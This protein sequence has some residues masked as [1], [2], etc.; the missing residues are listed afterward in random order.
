MRLFALVSAITLVGVLIRTVR[1]AEM[2][3]SD[4]G[5]ATGETVSLAYSAVKD[6]PTDRDFVDRVR[7]RTKRFLLAPPTSEHRQFRVTIRNHSNEFMGAL[8][9]SDAGGETRR[10]IPGATCDEVAEA[11]AL[12]LA[13]T[14]DPQ[15]DT[16]P[17]VRSPSPPPI[18]ADRGALPAPMPT[19]AQP[20]WRFAF[21]GG[22]AAVLGFWP[23]LTFDLP[24]TVQVG[25][26]IEGRLLFPRFGLAVADTPAIAI[27]SPNG[28]VSV[29][30]TRGWF[31]VCPWGSELISRVWAMPCGKL[32]L[33]RI[34]A[35]GLDV[36][37]PQRESR[38]WAALGASAR[39]DWA[40]WEHLHF[41]I[42]LGAV[43]PISSYFVYT[44]PSNRI[45][46][47]RRV[48]GMG[49]LVALLQFP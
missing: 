32:E 42:E 49:S 34:S 46:T 27:S 20:V 28:S 39:L 30:W 15:A 31:T 9:S 3:L 23:S 41:Q 33:G 24:I 36:P 14:I 19:S 4:T 47:I 26:S 5:G 29:D 10:E 35:L 1:A 37:A 11:L 22:G 17:H 8:E 13:L 43:A 45:Y 16:R 18:D 48:G 44:E 6:C 38:V 40:P 2:N 25:R 7:A 21:G 12:V